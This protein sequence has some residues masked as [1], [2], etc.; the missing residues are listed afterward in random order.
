MS[1][2]Q[3]KHRLMVKELPA[4]ALFSW[5]CSLRLNNIPIPSENQKKEKKEKSWNVSSGIN[6]CWISRVWRWSAI[7]NYLESIRDFVYNL[8]NVL[9]ENHKNCGD[10]I[11]KNDQICFHQP[12]KPTSKQFTY[13]WFYDDLFSDISDRKSEFCKC[14][15]GQETSMFPRT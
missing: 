2:L 10:F 15:F 5:W 8:V 9:S 11:Q 13:I 1:E 6:A 12:K 4:V 14:K 3:S 7:F